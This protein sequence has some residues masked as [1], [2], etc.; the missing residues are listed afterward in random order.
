M[1]IGIKS[2]AEIAAMRRAGAVVAEILSILKTSIRQGMKTREL[3]V[4]AEREL[5]ARG[6]GRPSRDTA[7]TR[8]AC[9]FP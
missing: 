9:A 8:P 7:A 3:D 2:A 1:T 4:I 6:L 5:K